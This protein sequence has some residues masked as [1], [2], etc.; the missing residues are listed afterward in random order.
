VFYV[1][2]GA[3]NLKV[4]DTTLVLATGAMFLV[5]RGKHPPS[6][7][8]IPSH[9]S[10]PHAL[11]GNTYFI[12]NIGDRP[13]KL[14]FT[15]ARKV[16]LEE[17]EEGGAG[18]GISAPRRSSE[19]MPR[20]VSVGAPASGT[21]TGQRSSSAGAPS[22]GAAGGDGNGAVGGRKVKRAMSTRT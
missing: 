19:S 1:I 2:E 9:H 21:G 4:H 7:H 17:E 15:Q 10:R 8:P 5:P 13:A 12:E 20:R 22:G 6:L 3:V 11:P 16:A 18:N 14:F